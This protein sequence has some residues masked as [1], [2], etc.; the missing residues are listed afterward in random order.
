MNFHKFGAKFRRKK[1]FPGQNRFNFKIFT[2]VN[3]F[4]LC[5]LH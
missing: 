4:F 1:A 2:I 5:K 3:L